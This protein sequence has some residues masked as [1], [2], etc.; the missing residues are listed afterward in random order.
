[1]ATAAG[2]GPATRWSSPRRALPRLRRHR[3]GGLEAAAARSPAAAEPAGHVTTPA[4]PAAET[5]R[6]PSAVVATATAAHENATQDGTGESAQGGFAR[7]GE[8]AAGRCPSIHIGLCGP[9]R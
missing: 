3:D 5:A 8:S 6:E 4:A 2:S 9:V 1:M 7:T